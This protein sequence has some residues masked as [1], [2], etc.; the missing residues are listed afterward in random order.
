MAVTY[1]IKK[2]FHLLIDRGIQPAER[3]EQAGFSAN[4]LNPIEARTVRF[5]GQYRKDR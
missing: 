2:L 4:I 5:S 3:T 1:K